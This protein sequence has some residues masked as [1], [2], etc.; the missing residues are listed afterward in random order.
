MTIPH[1]SSLAANFI[2]VK[3]HFFRIRYFLCTGLSELFSC[4]TFNGDAWFYSVDHYSGTGEKSVYLSHYS[5]PLPSSSLGPSHFCPLYLSCIKVA[6]PLCTTGCERV[7]SWLEFMHSLST[8]CSVEWEITFSMRIIE[9]GQ[10]GASSL[11]TN[12][13]EQ[14]H[15]NWRQ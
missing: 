4:T 11:P 6:I 7:N 14:G 10:G 8:I 5:I 15:L 2:F 3:V 13:R 9:H 1:H 12:H